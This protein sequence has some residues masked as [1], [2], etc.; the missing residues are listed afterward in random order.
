LGLPKSTPL[1]VTGLSRGA[2]MAVFS[3]AHEDLSEGV[4]GAVAIALTLESDYIRAPDPAHRHPGLQVDDKDRIL[5]Y[6]ILSRLAP[7][8][9]AV[10]QSTSDRYCSAATSRRLM[11]PD[12]PTLRL[13]PVKAMNHGFDGGRRQLFAFLDEALDWIEASRAKS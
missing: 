9:V 6:P 2:D 3:A 11:G 10:I 8:P 4:A 5:F 13:Y 12:T 7:T 1:I